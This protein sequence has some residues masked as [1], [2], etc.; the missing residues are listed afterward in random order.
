M[1]LGPN[2]FAYQPNLYTLQNRSS[3]EQDR[4]D[5]VCQNYWRTDYILQRPQRNRT[6]PSQL[7]NIYGEG[8]HPTQQW[9]TADSDKDWQ[10]LTGNRAPGLSQPSGSSS[11]KRPNPGTPFATNNPQTS[12]QNNPEGETDNSRSQS[13]TG[14]HMDVDENVFLSK[15]IHEGRVHTLINALIMKATVTRDDQP[16]FF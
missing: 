6:V 12:N 14:E 5:F 2:P 15:A 13:N 4:R 1:P 7:G 11:N 16:V 9:R 8:I 3:L 10:N